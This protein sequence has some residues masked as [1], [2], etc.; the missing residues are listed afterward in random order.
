MATTGLVSKSMMP[1]GVE[2]IEVR[3]AIK[4]L[5]GVEINDAER[6]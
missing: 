2:H 4:Q 1:K 3:D 6:R 5:R